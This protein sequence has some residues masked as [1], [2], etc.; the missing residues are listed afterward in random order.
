[1][2]KYSQ[3]EKW[4]H[5]PEFIEYA[6]NDLIFTLRRLISSLWENM[7]ALNER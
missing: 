1:M 3:K 6:S 5:L 7:Q 4:Q 2:S